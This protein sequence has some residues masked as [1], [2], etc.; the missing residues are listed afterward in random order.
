MSKEK[1]EINQGSVQ[2]ERDIP[3]KMKL[4]QIN[5]SC[6]TKKISDENIFEG[7]SHGF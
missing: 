3:A 7:M 6:V 2:Y 1:Q 5:P 4:S